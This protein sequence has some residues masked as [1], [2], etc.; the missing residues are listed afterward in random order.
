MA[1]LFR[2]NKI[3]TYHGLGTIEAA[4]RVRVTKDD[5]STETIETASI[6]VATG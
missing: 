6:V 2:K 4:G 3:D 5:G 1:F